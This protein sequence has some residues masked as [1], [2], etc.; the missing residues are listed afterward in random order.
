M[1][2]KLKYRCINCGDLHDTEMEAIRCCPNTAELVY[3]CPECGEWW[4]TEDQAK[5]CCDEDN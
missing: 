3:V 4:N 1:P 2:V 5:N